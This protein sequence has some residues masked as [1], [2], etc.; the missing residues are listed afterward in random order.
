[1]KIPTTVLLPILYLCESDEFFCLSMAFPNSRAYIRSRRNVRLDQERAE[2]EEPPRNRSDPAC[3]CIHR[4]AELN[5]RGP[6]TQRRHYKYVPRISRS[7]RVRDTLLFSHSERL[8]RAPVKARLSPRSRFPLVSLPLAFR[9]KP[10]TVLDS[11]PSP[12]FAS[13][14]ARLALLHQ[15]E[16]TTSTRKLWRPRRKTKKPARATEITTAIRQTRRTRAW[17]LV[18]MDSSCFAGEHGLFYFILWFF[19]ISMHEWE[20]SWKRAATNLTRFATPQ[21]GWIKK[22]L[23]N[24]TL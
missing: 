9:P 6:F 21:A 3:S 22:K 5:E 10:D 12:S 14:I 23:S 2:L 20:F 24:E 15:R 13:E 18:L 11:S 1:M 17:T 4:R 7:T 8:A 19:F 16:N